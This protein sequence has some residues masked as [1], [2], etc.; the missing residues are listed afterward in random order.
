M[1][2]IPFG[3]AGRC[4]PKADLEEVSAEVPSPAG[5]LE[6]ADGLCV[7]VNS[8]CGTR[9]C[10]RGLGDVVLSVYTS[11]SGCLRMGLV[12]FFYGSKQRSANLPSAVCSRFPLALAPGRLRPAECPPNHPDSLDA[13][14]SIKTHTRV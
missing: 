3:H 9:R 12:D 1:H 14:Y 2:P 10:E 7:A 5:A 13:L 6:G 11:P 4:H 8:A